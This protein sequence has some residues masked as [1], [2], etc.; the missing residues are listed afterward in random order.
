MVWDARE[1]RATALRGGVV[2]IYVP[3]VVIG[4]GYA[5]WLCGSAAAGAEVAPSAHLCV[6]GGVW[7]LGEGSGN[8][9]RARFP[10]GGRRAAC[11]ASSMGAWHPCIR[12]QDCNPDSISGKFGPSVISGEGSCIARVRVQVGAPCPIGMWACIS[13]GVSARWCV[14]M[15]PYITVHYHVFPD[16]CHARS[17]SIYQSVRLHEAAVFRITHGLL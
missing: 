1:P 14:M 6:C 5:D 13:C 15:G 4:I 8:V 17:R 9:P 12:N 7:H 10:L 11:M 16:L 2:T 3:G